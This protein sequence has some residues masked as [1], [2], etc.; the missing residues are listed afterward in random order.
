[1]VTIWEG[2]RG[3]GTPQEIVWSM[4]LAT[5]PIAFLLSRPGRA[6]AVKSAELR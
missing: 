6:L 3:S 4:L 1:M 2:T 5:A